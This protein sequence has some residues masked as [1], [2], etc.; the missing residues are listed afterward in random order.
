[1]LVESVHTYNLTGW[2]RLKDAP[3]P[4]TAHTLYICEDSEI[5]ENISLR[6]NMHILCLSGAPE[7][8]DALAGQVSGACHILFL[9]T[10]GGEDVYARLQDY[11][12]LQCS[13]GL[14]SEELLNI[15]SSEGGIQAMIDCAYQAFGNPIAV[16][17]AYFNLIAA[18]WDEA[19]KV[20][21]G[22]VLVEN[23]GFSAKEF[24]MANSR[25]HIHK[26][27]QKSEVP[28]M[29]YNPE[30]G[31]DQLLCAIDTKKDLGHIVVSAVNQSLKPIDTKLLQVLKKSIAQQLKKDEF[32]QN[33][34]G[35]NYES[36]LK[37]L[38]EERAVTSKPFLDRLNHVFRD[39]QGNMYCLTIETIHSPG[40]VN[41]FH[42]RDS[43]ESLFPNSKTLIYNSQVIGILNVPERQLL[44]QKHLDILLRM[45]VEKGLYA[46][47]S[48]CFR[49]IVELSAYHKQALRAMEL[50]I[51]AANRP[52]LFRY[53]SFGLKH[54]T[55]VF[56]QK[57]SPKTFCHP[58]M[59]ALLEYDQKHD[60]QLA[61][62][63][64]I[65]LLN[66]RNIAATSAAM[67]MHR[68]SVVYR[69]KKIFSLVGDNFEDC[70]ERQYLILSYQLM[71]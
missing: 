36:L 30:I 4:Y 9:E 31:C 46:G 63:L 58:K 62:T 3:M 43:L 42:I 68:N 8:W 2:S 47:L 61:Y 7:R 27:V 37:D 38:L 39:F 33:M 70:F 1:M 69:I 49:N 60:S 35:D 23:K 15:L 45:C 41:V 40:T 10:H 26:R 54:I 57:E 59:K 65:Y 20:N 66:E 67:H 55:S 56:A 16:F 24:E 25:D 18:N 29:A 22:A 19:K 71:N 64:Y 6:S 12:D 44:S 50:G 34:K 53:E 28:I 11:F 32:V 5:S 17:D 51:G 48:N 14:F 21:S 13:V 52:S